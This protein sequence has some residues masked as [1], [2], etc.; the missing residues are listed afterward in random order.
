MKAVYDGLYILNVQGKD[1]NVKE[2]IDALESTIRSE[3]GE[4]LGCQKMDRRRFERVAQ[5]VEFGFYVNLIF[6]LE[7]SRIAALAEAQEAHSFL[8]RQFYLRKKHAPEP[9]GSPA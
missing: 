8:L 4:V 6:S 9:A 7:P 2:A 3:G 1:E 5:Q